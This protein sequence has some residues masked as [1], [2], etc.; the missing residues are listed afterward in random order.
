MVQKIILRT[1]YFFIGLL[2]VASFFQTPKV[3]SDVVV[4]QIPNDTI[5]RGDDVV[6]SPLLVEP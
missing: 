4:H 6:L 3:Y 1:L 5:P 2:V